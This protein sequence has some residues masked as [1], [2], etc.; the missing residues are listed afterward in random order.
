MK[1]GKNTAPAKY[2]SDLSIKQ[3][4]DALVNMQT[5][6]VKDVTD[7]VK[8]DFSAQAAKLKTE[9]LAEVTDALDNHADELVKQISN[10]LTSVLPAIINALPSPQAPVYPAAPPVY[11]TMSPYANHPM[12]TIYQTRAMPVTGVVTMQ[13]AMVRLQTRLISLYR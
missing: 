13:L 12:Y 1:S 5:S 10:K 9:I 8:Q 11:Q 3:V 7:I 6:L 2:N 4:N